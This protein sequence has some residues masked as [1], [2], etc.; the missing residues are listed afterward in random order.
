MRLLLRLAFLFVCIIALGDVAHADQ[1][2]NPDAPQSLAALW[3]MLGLALANIT[4]YGT[5][6]LSAKYTFFHTGAGA[7]VLGVIGAAITAGSSRLQA[8]HFSWA[9]LAWAAVGGA[10]SFV[11][12]LNP[13]TT[14]DDPPAKSPAAKAAQS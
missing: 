6:K 2:A 7:I 13:S 10:T 11:A 5:R 1:L 14:V 4:A 8:G 3:P 12:T 9:A